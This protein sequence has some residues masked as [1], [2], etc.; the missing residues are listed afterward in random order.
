MKLLFSA[1]DESAGE[2][3]ANKRRRLNMVSEQF[4]EGLVESAQISGKGSQL[5]VLLHKFPFLLAAQSITRTT[6][7]LKPIFKITNLNIPCCR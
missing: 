1:V 4:E 7:L 3:Q 6:L 2:A 5:E